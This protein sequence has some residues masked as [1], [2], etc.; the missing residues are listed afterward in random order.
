MNNL[1][2]ASSKPTEESDWQATFRKTKFFIFWSLLK[3]STEL[4]DVMRFLMRKKG[5][6]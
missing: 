6:N 3:A 2:S 1:V 4:I 5:S